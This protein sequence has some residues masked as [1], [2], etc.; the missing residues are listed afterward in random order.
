MNICPAERDNA[1]LLYCGLVD[2][3]TGENKAAKLWPGFADIPPNFP[4]LKF[5]RHNST[6]HKIPE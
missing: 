3:N 2:K 6:R 1:A 4:E 5:F